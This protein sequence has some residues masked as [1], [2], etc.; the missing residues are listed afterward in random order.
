MDGARAGGRA[1]GFADVAIAATAA[2]RGLTILTRN[3]R[4]FSPLGAQAIDPF[5]ALPG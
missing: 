1:P 5:D 4:H 3:L 2:S